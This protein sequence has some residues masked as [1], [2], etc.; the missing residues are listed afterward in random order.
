MIQRLAPIHTTVWRAAIVLLTVDTALDASA[1]YFAGSDPAPPPIL[2]NAFADP[3][4]VLHVASAMLALVV[5]PLQFVR[6]VRTRWPAAHRLTGR[7]F[8]LGCA[9][10]APTGVV[11][12]IGTTAGPAVQVGFAIPGLLCLAFTALGWRAAVERRFD[13]HADWMLRAYAMIAGAI[14]LRLMLPTATLLMGIDFLPA[15]RV[16]A[17]AA[18]MTNLGLAEA[19]IRRRRSAARTFAVAAPAS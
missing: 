7:L 3:F 5:G 14:T 12:A 11:L 4:L 17:W 18:W 8:M 13:D 9:I 2:A 10:G 1:R 19:Y 16:I 6:A 15:Y